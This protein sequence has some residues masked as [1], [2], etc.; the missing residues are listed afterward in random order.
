M[1]DYSGYSNYHALQT[2]VTRRFDDG[3]MF[4][5][6]YVWSKAL[7]INNNDFAAG[8]PNLSEEETRRLD[9]S[10]LDYDRPHN[11][12]INSIYQMPRVDRRQGARAAG[13]RLADLGRLPLDER[14]ARTASA[15][16]FRASAPP[17][18][19]GT[20]GNPNARIVLTCDPGRGWSGD[21]VQ[22]AQHVVLRT[23]AA[24][25]RRRRIG[26]VLRARAADQQPRPVALEDLPGRPHRQVR[27]AARHVQ[28]AE[29]H[30]VHRRQLRGRTSP[31]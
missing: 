13:Q 20:D 28:R 5:G 14:P 18:L 30:A 19:T 3:F 16:R 29:P 17:N 22:A 26:A 9:Y 2:S 8:V 25:Q 31:A 1:W 11:F 6:F 12:V 24:G 27:G 4:S 15:S 21:P 10:L 7:G 23:A